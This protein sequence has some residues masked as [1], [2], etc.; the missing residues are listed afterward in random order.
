MQPKRPLRRA[1][2]KG[3]G[4]RVGES[5]AV[6]RNVAEV[7]TAFGT[8]FRHARQEQGLTILELHLRTGVAQAF[9]SEMERGKAN[10][11]LQTI[12]VLAAA[13]DV[14]VASLFSPPS[15]TKSK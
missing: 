8:N 6:L 13:V 4:T 5:P 9:I 15:G 2:V 1:K 11:S 14:D 3:R 12:T 10:I 7:L